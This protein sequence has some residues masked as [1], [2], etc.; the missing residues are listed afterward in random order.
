LFWLGSPDIGLM[1]ANYIGYW[2]LGA[3]LLS[4]GMFSS[5]LTANVTIAF[6]LGAVFCSFF[7][8]IDSARLVL[9]DWLQGFFTPLGIFDNFK[10]FSR[11]IIS[12]SSVLFF[13]SLTSTM[14]YFNVVILGKRHWPL[15]AGGYKFWIHQLVRAIA[16]I[17]AIISFNSIVG[18]FSFRLDT[19]AEQIHSL[20]DESYQSIKELPEKRP[21]LIQAFISP[22]VPREYVETRSNLIS[23][24][25]EISAI[26][27]DKV[28]VLIHNAEPF[29]EEAR[30]AREKFGIL[31]NKIV[32]S[33]SA[34]SRTYDVF[35]G[36]TFTSGVNEE[37]IPFFDRG[38]PVEYE[39]I[40]SIRIAAKS[41]RKKI[42]VLNTQAKLFGEFNFQSM[43]SV[44]AW[45]V[46]RELKKQYDVVQINAANEINENLDALL[47]V[48]PSSLPQ[49]EM[50]NLQKY[51]LAGN[52][53]MLLVDPVPLFNIALSPVLPSGADRNPMMNQQAQ[54]PEPKGN[55]VNL[56]ST[57]GVNWNGNQVIWDTYNPHP[58]LMQ[59]QPE[60]IFIGEGNGNPEPFTELNPSSAG[61]QELVAIYPGYLF[62][63]I[64]SPFEF[65]PLLK[66]GKMSG[67]LSW[68]K[69]VR[70]GFFGFGFNLNPNPKRYPSNESYILA[71]HIKGENSSQSADSTNIIKKVNVIIVSDIDFI[72]EQFFQIRQRGIENL[73]F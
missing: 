26:A 45:S 71:A 43:S 46:V 32:S 61:L 44:P 21:V 9:S 55:I 39:I 34:Q 35:L 40:R 42:G 62:K 29:T 57:I 38:L 49:K 31:P 52:P 73:N 54:Q 10:D 14:L 23:K 60:V 53:T 67:V 22:E 37:V 15:E 24:L 4:V 41:E 30:D 12:F 68:D 8:F 48:L 58:D 27:G 6:I 7:I 63:G 66:T 50:D 70:R 18:Y 56:M 11:G 69:V 17:I 72:S 13:I 1:L 59:I 33:Q 3:A 28:Q 2:F 20:S 51:I 16:L 19:T 36:V 25:Q 65:Q 64:N 47:V 5:L